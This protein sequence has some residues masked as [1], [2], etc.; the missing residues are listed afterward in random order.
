[1]LR[2]LAPL[3]LA[4]AAAQAAPEPPPPVEKQAQ[5]ATEIRLA[6]DKER[7][8]SKKIRSGAEKQL[9][10]AL[11]GRLALLGSTKGR[12]EVK[13]PGDIRVV[14]HS[15]TVDPIQLRVFTRIG[16]WELRHLDEVQTSLNPNGRVQIDVRTIQDANGNQSVTRFRDRKTGALIEAEDFFRQCPVLATNADFNLGAARS[17]TGGSLMAVRVQLTLPASKKLRRFLQKP[18][19]VVGMTLDGE[20]V[21]LNVVGTPPKRKK[22][23]PELGPEEIDILAGFSTPEECGYLAVLFNAPPLPFPVKVLGTKLIA[24]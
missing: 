8:D 24:E 14:V 1:M 2:L 20:V 6:V 18:G 7:I 19:R 12:V 15:D 9:E 16:R 21:G 13:S 4:L 23:D 17:V 3:A 5:F 11:K 22:G 10:E